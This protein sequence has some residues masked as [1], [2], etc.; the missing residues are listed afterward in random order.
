MNNIEYIGLDV[1]KKSI[2]TCSKNAAG[3]ILEKRRIAASRQE[4][5]QW[6]TQRQGPFVAGVEATM[7]TGWVYDYLKPHAVSVKV[8]NPLL[9]KAISA[10]KHQNDSLDAEQM[11]D[12]LRVD[13]VP[14]SYMAPVEI[15]DLRR[16][17][18]YRSL[19]VRECTRMKNRAASMLMECG[20]EYNKAK[21]H[22][23]GYF[24]ALLEELPQ[25]LDRV[26]EWL[27]D[28]LKMN[29]GA[30]DLFQTCQ[31]R[32]LNALE[33]N[34]KLR[35]RVE[36]LET[37]GGVGQ[38]VAVTWVLEVGEV[39][40]LGSIRK[41]VSFCGLCSGESQSGDK[42][43]RTPLSKQ[44]NKYLQSVLIEAAKVAPLWNPQLKE[45]HE[46]ALAHGHRNQATLAV[47]R[48]LVAYMMAVDRSGKPFEPKMAEAAG[49]L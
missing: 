46:R 22:H 5:A 7:F 6:L 31:Q 3:E 24:E 25:Q 37:I 29:R 36:R 41:A 28:L 49:S 1:H 9:A 23:K 47:A 18:R 19:L 20:V 17:L 34:E 48:K 15:R 42:H 4:L 44:R 8:I 21:L 12:M 10:G 30:I 33:Q 35:L 16:V 39:G 13:W 2:T 26:P 43:Y 32:L 45:V 11:S 14:E 38:V 40:R 27:L